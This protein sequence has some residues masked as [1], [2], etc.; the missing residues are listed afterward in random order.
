MGIEL[1][2]RVWRAWIEWRRFF[3]RNFLDLSEQLRSRGLVEAGLVF[4]AQNANGLQQA[5]RPET[6]GVGGVFRRLERNL[7]MRLRRQIVDLARLS[8][9]HDA[10]DI[11]G[12]RHIAVMQMK[13]NALLLGIMNEMIE[14]LGIEGR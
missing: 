5:Q 6:V 8:L 11:G 14:P 13:R 10:D 4:P 2:R 3:L 9:L 1:R 7:H 12:V